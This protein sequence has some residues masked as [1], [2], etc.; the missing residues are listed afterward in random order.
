MKL[1]VFKVLA[2]VLF[3][4]TSYSHTHQ[5]VNLA[6][7]SKAAL[8]SMADLK[9][10][11]VGFIMADPVSQ[12]AFTYLTPQNEL[13]LQLLSHT[14]GKCGGFEALPSNLTPEYYRA[15]LAQ[16][17]AITLKNNSWLR[18]PWMPLQNQI[19]K[20]EIVQTLSM[21]NESNLRD[22]VL[23]MSSFKNR[24]EKNPEGNAHIYQL[25]TKV[26]SW[27]RRRTQGRWTVDLISHSSTPQ[28]SLRVRFIGSKRPNE[29][30][31]LGGHHD[32][33]N[34]S[35]SG[36]RD[37]APGADDNA[38]GSANLLEIVRVLMQSPPLERTVEIMWYAGE[39]AGLLGS[40]EIAKAYKAA[41]A[42]VVG[43]VQMDM[44]LFPGSGEMTIVN[45][46][47]NTHPWLQALMKQLNEVYLGLRVLD[48]RCGYGCSDHAS[49]TRQGFPTVLPFEAKSSQMNSNIHSAKDVVTPALSFKHSAAI[50]KLSLAIALEL[51]N[52]DIRPPK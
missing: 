26:E 49:W 48:D 28:K 52:S 20:P 51:G 12:V 14:Q 5:N 17:Q 10:L 18:I 42:D 35:W 30:I 46:T 4:L 45:I 43:V 1:V 27:L 13:R 47:D 36:N 7:P 25:K 38:S 50:A 41:K 8:A 44:T 11:G 2:L 3:S 34:H 15:Q 40:A 37:V 29:I 6:G 39:E 32:S 23:W 9:R 21:I 31:V 24:H 16:L 22:T 19:K 33:I